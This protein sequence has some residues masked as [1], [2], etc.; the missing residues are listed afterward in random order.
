MALMAR[1]DAAEPIYLADSSAE[2]EPFGFVK[3][4]IC[5][6]QFR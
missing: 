2:F 1:P 4:S 6:H 3:P 5:H